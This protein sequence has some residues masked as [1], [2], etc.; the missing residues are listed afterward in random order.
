VERGASSS[1]LAREVDAA[2]P[3]ADAASAADPSR[4]CRRSERLM[5]FL[6]AA[7]AR[8]FRA[9]CLF[10]CIEPHSGKETEIGGPVDPRAEIPEI[11]GATR[12]SLYSD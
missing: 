6:L 8:S 10:S 12:Q 7:A 1:A 4:N 11:F 3:A 5:L 2:R 9:A